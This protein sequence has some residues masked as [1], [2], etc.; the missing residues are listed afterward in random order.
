MQLLSLLSKR[1][2]ARRVIM[3]VLMASMVLPGCSL[4]VM[5]GKLFFDDPK[6]K[7]V[8]RKNT[9]TDLTKGEKTILIAC[10]TS[11]QI[12][13]KYPGIRIDIVDKMSRILE[14][15]N[16]KIVPPDDVATWFDDHGEWGDFTELADEFDADYVMHIDLKSF[17]VV[18]P[19][20][21]NLLQGKTEGRVSMMEIKMAEKNKDKKKAS[22]AVERSF[23]VMFPTT[24]PVPRESRSEEMFTEN[25]LDR[26]SAQLARML[27]D[28]RPSEMDL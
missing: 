3:L 13:S 24:Y 14:T 25:F 1:H 17:A 28:H 12:L 20:S 27:Y 10:S 9:G 26:I 18:V 22:V 21:P 2:G 7:S 4:G 6:M 8:F 11:H 19:D 5:A 16:V 15:R 23:S